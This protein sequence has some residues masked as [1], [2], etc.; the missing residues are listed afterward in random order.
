MDE[1]GLVGGATRP[2]RLPLLDDERE[3]LR[4]AL[5]LLRSGVAA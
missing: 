4:A 3:A 5:T 1:V 2:P